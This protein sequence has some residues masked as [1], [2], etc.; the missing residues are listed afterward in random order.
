MTDA[1]ARALSCFAQARIQILRSRT[2]DGFRREWDRAL[3][4]ANLTA[5]IA[6]RNI[7]R[8]ERLLD[9]GVDPSVKGAA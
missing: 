8:A 1:R 4:C 5:A 7:A 3:A 9:A 6:W 2:G